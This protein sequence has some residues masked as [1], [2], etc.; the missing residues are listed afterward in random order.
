MLIE[1]PSA[2]KSSWN[3]LRVCFFG[4]F[5]FSI[6][7]SSKSFSKDIAPRVP[8]AKGQGGAPQLVA[9]TSFFATVVQWVRA[10]EL[11]RS[12]TQAYPLR[13]DPRPLS[14]DIGSLNLGEHHF[15]EVDSS[16]LH[17][18]S[19]VLQRLGVP[20]RDAVTYSDECLFAC[21]PRMAKE[22]DDTECPEKRCKVT[23]I[24]LS[25]PIKSETSHHIESTRKTIWLLRL[26]PMLHFLHELTFQRTPQGWT[27]IKKEVV[28]GGGM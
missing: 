7:I 3:A 21:D 4:V 1:R 13:I 8:C 17:R 5:L 2:M 19:A 6:L 24:V 14:F 11:V 23:V 9:D 10:N 16:V 20:Q 28:S 22:K 27:I 25:E 12:Q 15:A 26:T 18:R